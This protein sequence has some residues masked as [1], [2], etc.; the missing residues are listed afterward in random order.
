MTLRS[1]VFFMFVKHLGCKTIHW[2]IDWWFDI[3][4]IFIVLSYVKEFNFDSFSRV[5]VGSI[6]FRHGC[7]SDF[8]SDFAK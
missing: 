1:D 8:C 4:E 2:S 5:E 6:S 3:T 7:D